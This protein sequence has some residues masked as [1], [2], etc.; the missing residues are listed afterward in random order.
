MDTIEATVNIMK[1]LSEEDRR[2]IREYAER[3]M[4]ARETG[5]MV[6]LIPPGQLRE[7]SIDEMWAEMRIG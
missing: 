7:V 2:M 5:A 3:V 6:H 4:A 1:R